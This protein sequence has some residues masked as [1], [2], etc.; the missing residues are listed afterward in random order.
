MNIEYLKD[1]R[2]P[3][4]VGRFCVTK[5][6]ISEAVAQSTPAAV[7]ANRIRDLHAVIMNAL[8]N[9]LFRGRGVSL[10][11]TD[12]GKKTSLSMDLPIENG[13]EF[14]VPDLEALRFIAKTKKLQ[15]PSFKEHCRQFN[16]RHEIIFWRGA[17]TGLGNIQSINHLNSIPRIQI[18]LS[19]LS[20]SMYDLRISSLVQADENVEDELKEWM[21]D[22]GIFAEYVC[23]EVFN[24]YFATVMM[25][26]N[27]TPWGVLEKMYNGLLIIQP[28]QFFQTLFAYMLKSKHH[29]IP[30]PNYSASSLK[31][32]AAWCLSNKSDASKIAWR[33]RV[34]AYSYLSNLKAIYIAKALLI[35]Y[36]LGSTFLLWIFQRIFN[37]YV[38]CFYWI[39]RITR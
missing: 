38:L 26:G 2:L 11:Y 37:A 30:I 18:C 32:T 27:A 21:I 39:S 16:R 17:T 28:R 10:C 36:G 9:W 3:K 20:C 6:Q 5:V 35:K 1:E 34:L 33:G 25:P 8:P 29:C 19:A 24:D 23:S 13:S 22:E 15:L 12:R 7:N 31:H 14:L 4:G